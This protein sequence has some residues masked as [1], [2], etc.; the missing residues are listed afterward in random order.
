MDPLSAGAQAE[1]FG[2]LTHPL[3]CQWSGTHDADWDT[4]SDA[5]MDHFAFVVVGEFFSPFFHFN[6][7]STIFSVLCGT[8]KKGSSLLAGSPQ[9]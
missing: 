5:Q 3:R 2:L 6:W 8:R 9:H 4:C 1:P 7:C